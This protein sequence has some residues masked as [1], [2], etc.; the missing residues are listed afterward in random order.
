MGH[1]DRLKRRQ[2][3]WQDCAITRERQRSL[4]EEARAARR[5][6]QIAGPQEHAG[7]T[8]ALPPQMAQPSPLKTVHNSCRPCEKL[9]RAG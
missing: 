6:E 8:P 4:I 5:G 3:Q 7:I 9:G 1:S 2:R